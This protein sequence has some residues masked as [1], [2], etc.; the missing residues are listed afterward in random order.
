MSGISHK[1]ILKKHIDVVLCRLPVSDQELE[2]VRSQVSAL[3]DSYLSASL[4]PCGI[5]RWFCFWNRKRKR[6]QHPGYKDVGTRK[7]ASI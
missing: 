3:L 5:S 6:G 1:H 7:R 2:E 4:A